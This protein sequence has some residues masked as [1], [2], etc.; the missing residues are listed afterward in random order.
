MLSKFKQI[1]LYRKT[2]SDL[3]T[4]TLSGGIFS[5]LSLSSIL[6]LFLL[7]TYSYLFSPYKSSLLIESSS[8]NR[9]QVDLDLTFPSIPCGLLSIAYVDASSEYYT[10]AFLHKYPIQQ[11]RVLYEAHIAHTDPLTPKGC[12]SCY[13]AELYEGQC[14]NTCEE[15]MEAY[16]SRNW[17]PPDSESIEQCKHKANDEGNLIGEGCL[18]QGEIQTRKIPGTIRIELNPFG[19]ALMSQLRAPYNG[20]HVVNHIGFSDPDG[21]KHR[22]ALD[23]KERKGN[24]VNLYFLKVT[25]AVKDGNRFY[26]VSDGY[27]GLSKMDFPLFV[28][29]YDLDPITTVYKPVKSFSEYIVSICAIIGGWFAVSLLLSKLIIS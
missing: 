2:T 19:K 7:E 20:D 23:G 16:T 13:G 14:C 11:G 29:A 26:E 24:Y 1:D 27:L 25:A 6:L 21:Y 22:A 9:Y 3:S 15:V 17:R 4:Q 8:S 5:L 10:R 18:L 28:I 12:G